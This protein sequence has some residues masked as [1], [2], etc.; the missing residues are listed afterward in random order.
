MSRP[1]PIRCSD[2]WPNNGGPT[3]T[4]ALLVGSPAIDKGDNA[5][6]PLADQRGVDRPQP[7]GGIVDIGAYEFKAPAA[8]GGGS[9]HD[10]DHHDD[11]HHH[12]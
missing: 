8:G 1:A 11:D 10:D 6:A 3:K 7:A 2:R 9:H 5:L 4:Y 12:H